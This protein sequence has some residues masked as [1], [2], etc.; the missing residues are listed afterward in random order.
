MITQMYVFFNNRELP[1][2]GLQLRKTEECSLNATC[3]IV[4]CCNYN[5]NISNGFESH[6]PS[7]IV[8]F[9]FT[10]KRRNDR[11]KRAAHDLFVLMEIVKS[12][13]LVPSPLTLGSKLPSKETKEEVS[14]S[15]GQTDVV[16]V[17]TPSHS[18]M[19]VPFSRDFCRKIFNAWLEWSMRD[20]IT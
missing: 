2:T 17:F 10:G 9:W 4:C 6:S 15:C 8:F 3:R 13:I 14:I 20:T 16:K 18:R 7:L 19:V 5:E 11:L 1:P 12:Q